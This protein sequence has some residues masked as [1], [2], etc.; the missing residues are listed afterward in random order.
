MDSHVSPDT[1]E[2][3]TSTTVSLPSKNVKMV[4]ELLNEGSELYV[5][6]PAWSCN[7]PSSSHPQGNPSAPWGGKPPSFITPIGWRGLPL[8]SNLEPLTFPSSSPEVKTLGMMCLTWD[9]A[10]KAL[11]TGSFAHVK[12]HPPMEKE[13]DQ[14]PQR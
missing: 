11:S 8:G 5:F 2:T 4:E 9:D 10:D 7:I 14:W 13:L 1:A 12:L 3:R 6:Q